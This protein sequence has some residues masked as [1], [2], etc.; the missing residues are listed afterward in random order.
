MIM[1]SKDEKLEQ[2]IDQVTVFINPENINSSATA[3]VRATLLLELVQ[4]KENGKRTDL[5]VYYIHLHSRRI[6]RPFYMSRN[7]EEA[8]RFFEFYRKEIEAGGYVFEVRT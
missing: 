8:L 5:W 7:E 1:S 4:L 6:N 3:P 2:I